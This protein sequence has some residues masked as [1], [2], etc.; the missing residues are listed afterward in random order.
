[1]SSNDKK[2][3]IKE[4]ILLFIVDALRA[5]EREMDRLIQKLEDVKNQILSNIEKQE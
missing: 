3:N 5:H 1:M 4:E 2:E